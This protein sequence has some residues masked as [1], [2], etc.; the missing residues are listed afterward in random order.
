MR[1]IAVGQ[2]F[3]KGY[4][5]YTTAQALDKPNAKIHAWQKDLND[6]IRD[7][8]NN[9]LEANRMERSA[10]DRKIETARCAAMPWAKFIK[11]IRTIRYCT[12]TRQTK[13][14]DPRMT[15]RSK[16]Q[17]ARHTKNTL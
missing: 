15:E 9:T 7:M 3:E 13:C 4:P 17:A 8:R 14:N 11:N 1:S 10:R 5:R 12:C 6:K 16:R 2:V